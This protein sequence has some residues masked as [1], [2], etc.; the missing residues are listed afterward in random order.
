MRR[1]D[2]VGEMRALL[3]WEWEEDRRRSSDRS[4]RNILRWREKMQFGF[5]EVGRFIH[6]ETS[7]AAEVTARGSKLG[8]RGEVC[9]E[10]ADHALGIISR[11]AL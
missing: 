5:G 11:T 8:S 1:D 7:A 3:T 2:L 6:R 9:R 4:K 10:I